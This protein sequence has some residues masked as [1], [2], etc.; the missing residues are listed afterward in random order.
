M[1]PEPGSSIQNFLG[2]VRSERRL[3]ANTVAAYRRDLGDFTAFLAGHMQTAAWSWADVDRLDIRAWLGELDGRGLKRSTISRKLSAV[4]AFY[5]FLHRTE[6]VSRNPARL[7]RT[8]RKRRELP[9]YLTR[10]Q[11]ESLFA[12]LEAYA[13]AERP[14]AIRDRAIIETVY[15]CGL[16]LSEVQ[17][18]DDGDLDLEKG[19]VKVTGKGGRERIVPVGGRA[20][21]ALTAYLARRS[22]VST[23]AGAEGDGRPL[24]ISRRGTRISRRQIQRSVGAWLSWAAEGESLSVHALRHTF[25][26]HMLDEGADLLAVK[27]LLGHSSL[28]TTRIYTHTS[29]ERLVKTYRQAHPRAD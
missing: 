5:R 9:G 8:P 1:S 27:E 6:V 21:E 2:Y 24:F 25:A 13:T 17:G 10:G 3:S 29:R 28:S 15:S 18:L 26:T 14:L 16:R 7:V 22:D 19:L 4:R 11:A 23:R 20:R 12:S